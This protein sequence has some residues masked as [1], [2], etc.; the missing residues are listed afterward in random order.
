MDDIKSA[1]PYLTDNGFQYPKNSKAYIMQRN[2]AHGKKPKNQ[3]AFGGQVQILKR[4]TSDDIINKNSTAEQTMHPIDSASISVLIGA[5][6]RN[7]SL[8]CRTAYVLATIDKNSEVHFISKSDQSD[9]DLARRMMISMTSGGVLRWFNHPGA[10]NK[11]YHSSARCELENLVLATSGC[12]LDILRAFNGH[13]CLMII[14]LKGANEEHVAEQIKNLRPVV[15][16]KIHSLAQKPQEEPATSD[17]TYEPS[18]L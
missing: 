7:I 10:T 13:L 9:L 11:Y 6:G 3:V 16:D 5:K 2:R 8:I 4:G 14:P 1:D 15:L 12:Y 18:A 17:P